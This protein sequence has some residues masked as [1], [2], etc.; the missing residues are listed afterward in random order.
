MVGHA[1]FGEPFDVELR[2][3]SPPSLYRGSFPMPIPR[4]TKF[5]S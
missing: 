3:V 2:E 1:M 4:E 5:M